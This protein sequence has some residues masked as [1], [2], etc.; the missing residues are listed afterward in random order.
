MMRWRVTL[1]LMLAAVAA[2]TPIPLDVQ[3]EDTPPGRLAG[4]RICLDPGHDL[5]TVPGAAARDASGRVLFNEHEMTLAVGLRVRELLQEEGAEVCLTRDDAG[6]LQTLP[7]D[8]NGNG[9]TRRAEDLAEWT[10]PRIDWM[11]QAGAEIVL[12]IHFNGHPNPGISGTEVYYS[13]TGPYL[14]NNWALAGNV[15]THLL[16]SIKAAGY[17]PV[18]RGLHSDAYK[19]EYLRYAHLYGQ[20]AACSDCRRLF[21]LGNNPMSAAMGTWQAGALVEVLFFSNPQDV[22]F[23]VRPDAVEVIAQGLTSGITAYATTG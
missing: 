12:S 9:T 14:D 16:A 5:A 20:S 23:L 15:L 4:R 17:G 1:P 18:D 8:F 7:Y 6:D 13:D 19:T 22:A 2:T 11:N 21:T 3:P 10:Q